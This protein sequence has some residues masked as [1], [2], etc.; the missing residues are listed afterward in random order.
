MQMEILEIRRYDIMFRRTDIKKC[1]TILLRK[2]HTQ[3]HISINIK[4]L[5]HLFEAADNMVKN[6]LSIC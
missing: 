4:T 3:I 5:Q 6:V 2:C 1:T